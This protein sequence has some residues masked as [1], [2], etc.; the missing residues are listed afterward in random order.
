MKV[1][2][3]PN[4]ILKIE[5]DT[6]LYFGGTAYLGLPTNKKFQQILIKNIMQWGTAYRDGYLR[7]TNRSILSFS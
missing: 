7:N 2:S 1:N 4:R 6:F 3:F 5:K